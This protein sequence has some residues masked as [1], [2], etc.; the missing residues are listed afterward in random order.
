MEVLQLAKLTGSDQQLPASVR[1]RHGTNTAGKRIHYYLN[2]SGESQTLDYAYGA[3]TD[4]LTGAS[5]AAASKV[6]VPP[7]ELI[8][9]EEGAR[10]R[11]G[12]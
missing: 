8:I 1:V 11:K 4:L 5:I 6:T 2:Y 3:G 7:W 9:V 12:R 10:A